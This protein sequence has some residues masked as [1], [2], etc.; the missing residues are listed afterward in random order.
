MGDNSNQPDDEKTIKRKLEEAKKEVTE[1]GGL[2]TF[3]S[4][5]WLFELVRKSFKNYWERANVDYFRDKYKSKDNDFIAKRLTAVA[6]QNA[7]ILGSV[8]GAVVSTDEI[9]AFFTGAEGGIGLP[10][11]IA[12]AATAM[13]SEA[14]VLVRFQLQLVANLGKLYGVP[15]DPDDPEDIFIILAFAVGG[16]AAEEAGK[17]GMKV[18]G[19]VA[20]KLVKKYISKETLEALKRIGAKIGLKILQRTILKY[21][22]PVVS[23]GVGFGWNYLATKTVGK[24]ARK[25]FLSRTKEVVIEKEP[26]MGLFNTFIKDPLLSKTLKIFLARFIS[27]FGEVSNLSIDTKSKAISLTLQLVGESE[28]V[29]I[30]VSSYEFIIRDGQDYFIVREFSTSKS[31]LDI[32][33]KKYAPNLQFQIPSIIKKIG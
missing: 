1:L 4:G 9:V 23:I 3:K 17:F 12:I 21:V 5:G 28:P 25:H 26:K 32:V 31:W 2:K 20:G 11:N 29:T 19:R 18:G 33:L 7:G 6:A 14:I 30:N 27:D 10:A 13:A 22:V 16:F 8:T 15:L 24:I